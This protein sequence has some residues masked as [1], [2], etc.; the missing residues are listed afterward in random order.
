[1]KKTLL[2]P[3]AFAVAGALAAGSAHAA[4]IYKT[5]D[6][7]VNLTG[8]VAFEFVRDEDDGDEWDSKTD[9]VDLEIK[10][11][12]KL[13]NGV[14]VFGFYAFEFA[15]A[16]WSEEDYDGVNKEPLRDHYLG[17]KK[18]GF[19][20]QYG[21]Q[22]YAVDYF[23]VDVEKDATTATEQIINPDDPAGGTKEV[24]LATY[25]ADGIFVAASH[26]LSLNDESDTDDATAYDLFAEYEVLDKLWVG[27]VYSSVEYADDDDSSVSLGAQI[28]YSGIKNLKLGASYVTTNDEA[29]YDDSAIEFAAKY[30]LT[31]KITLAGGVGVA[32]FDE[33]RGDSPK[34]D[35]VTAYYFNANYNFRKNLDF[36]AE[37]YQNGNTKDDGT[38]DQLGYLMG[39]SLDF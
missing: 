33:D 8:E 7:Y 17:L 39:V 13:D 20:V 27:G 4:N 30:K 19:T 9:N 29:D 10:A 28:E 15:D 34:Y 31:K 26:D 21:D 18:S 1:M 35:D 5:D 12:Y 6:A 14:E 37:V 36:Y 22:D 32:S 38:E 16:G 2:T 3:L 23:R 24:I 11:G 25:K